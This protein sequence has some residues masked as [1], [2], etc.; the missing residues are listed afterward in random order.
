MQYVVGVR[1][2]AQG[3]TALRQAQDRLAASSGQRQIADFGLRIL[4]KTKDR[5]QQNDSSVGAA[6]SRDDNSAVGASS[7]CDWIATRNC[8]YMQYEKE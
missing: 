3:E 4:K 2:K 5:G 7:A 1:H 8:S 6:F